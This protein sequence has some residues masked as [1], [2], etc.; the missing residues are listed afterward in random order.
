M[1]DLGDGPLTLFIGCTEC[2]SL[3]ELSK[4]SVAMAFICSASLIDYIKYVQTSKCKVCAG[5][6]L[7]LIEHP[8]KVYKHG[9][10]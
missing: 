9:M 8:L 7:K 5:S 10:D 4:D 6:E 1:L 2:E 3:F